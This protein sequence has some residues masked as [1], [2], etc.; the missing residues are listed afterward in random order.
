MGKSLILMARATGL[1]PATS[2]VTGRK[3][4]AH[5]NSALQFSAPANCRFSA[6]FVTTL[7]LTQ[8]PRHG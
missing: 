2:G 8:A 4:A 5:C 6:R 7:L 3:Y 1:E